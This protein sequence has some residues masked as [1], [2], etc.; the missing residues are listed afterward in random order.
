M[1]VGIDIIEVARIKRAIDRWGERFVNH[2]FCDGEISLCRPKRNPA[3]CFAAYFAAKEAFSK[4]LGTGMR[5]LRW[6]DIE[7]AHHNSGKPYL[8]IRGKAKTLL[9]NRK[10]DVSLSD[11]ESLA[12]AFVIIES[13]P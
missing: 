13:E 1:V 3:M 2:V 4:A 5:I 7:V 10:V 9:G 8:I 12:T 11:T 6:K